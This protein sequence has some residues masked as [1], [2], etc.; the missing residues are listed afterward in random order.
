VTCLLLACDFFAPMKKKKDKRKRQDLSQIK[1][2]LVVEFRGNLEKNK[3][4][5]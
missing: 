5:R 2:S 3:S 1:D 4:V